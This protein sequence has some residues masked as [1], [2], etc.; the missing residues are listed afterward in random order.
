MFGGP[1]P[2]KTLM[3]SALHLLSRFR[4]KI[5]I[6]PQSFLKLQTKVPED[7]AKFYNHREGP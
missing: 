3:E 6:F 1:P 5:S 7:Y 2:S 4:M